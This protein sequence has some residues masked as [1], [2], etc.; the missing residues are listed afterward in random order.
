MAMSPVKPGRAAGPF[1]CF[2]ALP[3]GRWCSQLSVEC[4]KASWLCSSVRIKQ[5]ALQALAAAAPQDATDR[6]RIA[7]QWE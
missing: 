5:V 2:G 6:W 3:V 7:C 4:Q 1:E